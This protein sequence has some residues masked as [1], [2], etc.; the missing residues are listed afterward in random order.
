MTTTNNLLKPFVCATSNSAT[1]SGTCPNTSLV[2]ILGHSYKG[3]L[4]TKYYEEHIH[5]QDAQRLS[6][7]KLIAH[8]FDDFDLHLSLSKCSQLEKE[9]LERFPTEKI[10]SGQWK[11]STFLP[12]KIFLLG[13]L[14]NFFE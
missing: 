8:Y 14:S 9:I 7:I 2:A 12:Y 6:L 10:V 3:K 4:L 11:N 13:I 5:F 1:K